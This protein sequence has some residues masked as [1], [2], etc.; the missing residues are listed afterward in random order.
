[1]KG[2]YLVGEIVDKKYGLRFEDK[3][4]IIF[5]RGSGFRHF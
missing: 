5:K 3:K 2:C 4:E 1:M